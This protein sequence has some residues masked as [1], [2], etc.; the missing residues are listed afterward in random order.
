MLVTNNTGS[1]LIPIYA[2]TMALWAT[3]FLE[4]WKRREN[5][6]KFCWDMHEFKTIEPERVTY[7]GKF[8]LS[9]VTGEVIVYDPFKS[10][11]RKVCMD[12]PI[13]LIGIGSAI[14]MFILFIY[15]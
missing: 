8:T 13:L 4:S 11:L 2:L 3:L 9:G 15:F 7:T 12:I 1:S 14:G 6:L 10:K 5:E